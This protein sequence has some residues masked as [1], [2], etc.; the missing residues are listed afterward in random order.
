MTPRTKETLVAVLIETARALVRDKRF[1]R[2]YDN[3]GEWT[4]RI[5][6]ALHEV[7]GGHTGEKTPN[8]P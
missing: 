2:V 6:T 3:G 4:H 7:L 5:E 8:E 1:G